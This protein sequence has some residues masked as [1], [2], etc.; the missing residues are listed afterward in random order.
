MLIPEICGLPPSSIE[1]AKDK[2]SNY[3]VN[4]NFSK[5]GAF[6]ETIRKFLNVVAAHIEGR[7]LPS[8]HI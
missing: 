8:V 2:K 5:I 3:I 1:G 6:K 4:V 7:I